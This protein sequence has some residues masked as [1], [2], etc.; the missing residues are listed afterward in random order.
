ME[1]RSSPYWD[2][3]LYRILAPFHDPESLVS[4]HV[5]SDILQRGLSPNS[6]EFLKTA[7]MSVDQA[8][9]NGGNSEKRAG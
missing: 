4:E 9:K 8:C 3:C 5:P 1:S 6:P 7:E 2:L